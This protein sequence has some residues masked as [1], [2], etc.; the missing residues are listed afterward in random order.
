MTVS[1]CDSSLASQC[2]ALCQTLASPG[3]AF[4]FSLKICINYSFSMDTMETRKHDC[5]SQAKKKSSPLTLRRNAKKR[6]KFL[7]HKEAVMSAPEPAKE[8]VSSLATE[9]TNKPPCNHT[10]SSHILYILYQSCKK[11]DC[12]ISLNQFVS[13]Y[14]DCFVINN[15]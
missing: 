11:C 6:L 1:E 15:E 5:Q 13:H 2:L 4:S 8:T 14:S 12:Y 3:K 7:G 9:V 10:G